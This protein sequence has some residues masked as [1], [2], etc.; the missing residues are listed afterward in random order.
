M[1]EALETD[2]H[3]PEWSISC[4]ATAPGEY[5]NTSEGDGEPDKSIPCHRTGYNGDEENLDS[6]YF[7][8]ARW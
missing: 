4:V 5:V 6:N 8:S 1:Q 3:G 2:T 7:R